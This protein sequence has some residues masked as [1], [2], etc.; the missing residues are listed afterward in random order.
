[1]HALLDDVDRT[2]PH[3]DPRGH[4]VRLKLLARG[5]DVRPLRAA[6]AAH[7]GLWNRDDARTAS[8]T[9]PHHGTHDIWCR[10]AERIDDFATPHVSIWWPAADVLPVREM[11]RS[12]MTLVG[13]EQLGGV[14][15]TRIPP[16]KMVKPHVDPGWHARFYDKVAVQIEAAPAQAFHFEGESLV[17]QPG[18]VFWFDNSFL[19]WVT[20]DSG[21]D[22]VTAIFCVRVDQS[23]P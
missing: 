19:H 6:L 20:N 23:G 1:M 5:W 15:I 18:D 3:C 4:G 7:P 11:A 22:R 9:S 21:R 13:A 16:G 10:F 2:S 12:V 8:P 14:L 17:T